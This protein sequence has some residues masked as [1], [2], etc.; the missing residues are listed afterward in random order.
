[1]SPPTAVPSMPAAVASTADDELL[2]RARSQWTV[3]R[4]VCKQKSAK[5]F[6]LLSNARPVVMQPG[7]PPVMVIEADHEFHYNS[8]REPANREVVEWAVLQVI[9]ATV[10]VRIVLANGNSS[11]GGGASDR[12]PSASGR[13]GSGPGGASG[14]G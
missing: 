13:G 8:L 11:T 3:I 1:A 14:A 10:R 9:E 6:G 12:G 7:T 4:R 2:A 5:I